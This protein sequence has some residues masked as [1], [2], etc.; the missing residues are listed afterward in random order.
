[1]TRPASLPRPVPPL[2]GS[3]AAEFYAHCHAERLCFQRCTACGAWRHLPR[4]MCAGCGSAEWTWE[5][6]SGRGRLH[7]WTVTH[8]PPHPAFAKDV[9]YV[10]AIVEL[11]EGVRMVSALR[12]VDTGELAL[13]LPVEVVFERV[14]DS[15]AL[16]CFRPVRNGKA[17]R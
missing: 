10:V 16:P 1:M 11:D 8:Q 17:G 15:V 7:S 14:S 3:L 5:A 4:W 9:P 6:S 13:G 2:Q 12:E